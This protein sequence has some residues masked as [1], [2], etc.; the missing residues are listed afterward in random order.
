MGGPDETI[1]DALRKAQAVFARYLEPG[2]PNDKQAVKQ[3]FG[4]LN[5]PAIIAALQE[6]EEASQNPKR[7]GLSRSPKLSLSDPLS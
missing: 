6:A 7:R 2:G 5:G 3:L 4:I 1:R